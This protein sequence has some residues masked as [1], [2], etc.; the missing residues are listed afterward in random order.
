MS[1]ARK[2]LWLTQRGVTNVNNANKHQEE[3]M[4]RLARPV[5]LVPFAVSLAF[6]GAACISRGAG[7]S[8]AAVAT[9]PA[10]G[11]AET[12][13]LLAASTVTNTG[14]SMIDGDVGV[15]P[16]TAIIG[17]PPGTITGGFHSADALAASAQTDLTTAYNDL[18]GQAC[19][20]VL[21]GMDLG[22]MTLMPGVYCFSTSAQSS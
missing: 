10:M 20:T 1:L 2:M 14:P 17:F 21:T 19:D 7:T 6:A 12:F 3:P 16:G 4:T 15:S 18:A 5:L 8:R 11:A 9:M 13:V 22:G